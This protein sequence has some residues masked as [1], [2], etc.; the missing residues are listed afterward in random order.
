MN[1]EEKFE[2]EMGL[3]APQEL[4][5]QDIAKK[6]MDSAGY[7]I[8]AGILGKSQNGK[9]TPLDFYYRR[10][11]LGLEDAFVSARAFKKHIHDDT[12]K[13]LGLDEGDEKG[14]ENNAI[15]QKG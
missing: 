10:Y 3:K 9:N 7:I 13:M 1:F 6:C 8:F 5:P 14:G 12:A 11:H 15:N 4:T 2:E